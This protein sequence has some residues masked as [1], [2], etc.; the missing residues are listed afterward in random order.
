MSFSTQAL[1]LEVWYRLLGRVQDDYQRRLER[2]SSALKPVQVTID[3]GADSVMGTER[4]RTELTNMIDGL[5]SL[6]LLKLAITSQV[7]RAAYE[8]PI[9][10]LELRIQC[11]R[12]VVHMMETHL[13][14]LPSRIR[15]EQE[16]QHLIAQH[17][18]LKNAGHGESVMVERQR[19][20]AYTCA[21]PVLG[22]ED[23]SRYETESRSLQTDID[24]L[25]AELQGLRVS[26]LLRLQVPE[27]LA[28]QLGGFGVPLALDEEEVPLLVIEEV[29]AAAT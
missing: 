18:A 14:N 21:L 29:P 1:P 26:T 27:T 3:T 23:A 4:S 16:I 2:L 8:T 7:N 10:S 12:N 22:A 17:S 15:A 9:H 6:Q 25:E 28:E 13:S 11:L 24:H 19:L 5:Q 20:R